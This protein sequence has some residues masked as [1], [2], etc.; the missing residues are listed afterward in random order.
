MGNEAEASA[1][2]EAAGAV[3][4]EAIVATTRGNQPFVSSKCFDC[5]SFVDAEASAGMAG[6]EGAECSSS[7]PWLPCCGCSS[8]AVECATEASAV[9]RRLED[10]TPSATVAAALPLAFGGG[11]FG[12]WPFAG[13]G[14]LVWEKK[15]VPSNLQLP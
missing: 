9:P 5:Q 13:G 8:D 1:M 12:L 11:P 3:I 15:Q 2:N 6:T 14:A 10:N 4:I 7:A